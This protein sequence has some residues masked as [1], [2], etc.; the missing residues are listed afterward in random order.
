MGRDPGRMKP[1]LD[2]FLRYWESEHTDIRFG[3][4]IENLRSELPTSL[5]Y[6]EDDRLR[7]ILET[8]TKEN[9][10]NKGGIL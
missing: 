9:K 7:S 1:L 6:I 10:H 5:F 2:T 4:L 3:Q 8:K